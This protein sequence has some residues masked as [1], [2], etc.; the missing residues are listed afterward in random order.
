MIL[1]LIAVASAARS[2]AVSSGHR[3]QVIL[4]LLTPALLGLGI[5]R[6]ESTG[7]ATN[8]IAYA[9][10]AGQSV[11]VTGIVADD[12]R[13]RGS[14]LRIL[15][16][17][18][19]I[20]VG[21][22]QQTV[23][24]R[25]QVHIP[26][27]IEMSYGDRIAVHAV[28]TPTA[29]AESQYL[30]WLADRRV[31][32][33]ALA[34]SGSVELLG[35]ADIG[36]RQ[37]LAVETRRAL[38]GSLR[39]TLPAPLSGIAQGMITGRQDAIDPELRAK[40][41]DT[42]LSH[43]IV[44]S[45]SNLTL[46]TAIVMAA[47]AWLIG[48]RP[49][50]L[51]A[52]LAALAYGT[53]I[54]PD[55]PV[56]RAMWMAVVFAAAHMLGRG[57]SALYAVSAT[58]ALMVA[59]EPHVLL[60]LSFQLTLAGTLG[61]IVL[62]PSLAQDFLAGQRGLTGAVRDAAL[63]TL[64]ATLATMPLIV[65]HFERAALIGLLTN[66]V[67]TPLFSWMLLG[68]AATA[69]LGTVSESAASMLAWPLSWLPLRWL[70]LVAEQGS[71]IPGAGTAIQGFGHAHLVLVYAAML[72]AS[73]RPHHER[74]AR[75]SR[76]SYRT[77]TRAQ[78]QR[79][80]NP[81]AR[82]GL[83]F[84]P[85]L[86]SMVRPA[87]I[88][89]VAAALAA[90]LWLAASSPPQTRLMIHYFD[91]GQ[92]DSALL[93]APEGHTIL[94]DTGERSLD[95]LGAL[96][97]HLPSDTQRIDFVVITHPQ[98][99]HGEALWAVLDHYDLGQVLLSAQADRTSFGRRLIELLDQRRVTRVEARPGQQIEFG[100]KTDLILDILWPPSDGLTEQ[101]LSD[102]NSSSIVIRARF[103]DAAFLFTG[104]IN[105]EQ[106]LDL[107]RNPCPFSSHPCELRADVLKV[108]HQGS[109]NSSSTLFLD[110]VRP[111]L[112]ILSAGADNPYGH[113]HDEV[114]ASLRRIGA[115]PL[116]TAERGDISVA[117]DGHS[118]SLTTQR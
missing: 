109:R 63:V 47:S 12:P 23:D 73:A 22:E 107:A 85:N 20:E 112:A 74:V 53:L 39:A 86:G 19:R 57:A 18:E 115:T 102:P 96:R 72:I 28:L 100:G 24:D 114:I 91:V 61:I 82:V 46:L 45:G 32:A 79:T 118:I 92:G 16:D 31:A 9:E 64:V 81:I 40:L 21:S 48:R 77:Q 94:I 8:G 98:S 93:V 62:M 54:G 65:L 34:R 4:L 84:I 89:G 38:N 80:S 36:W 13:L 5:W 68:T 97:D 3:I 1:T 41:N 105:V 29:G 99:D 7:L 2:D 95:L 50:A 49:A 67:V 42:S 30:Q 76:P 71:Q 103:G 101:A 56:Q 17:A 35:R 6:A 110:A 70:V 117:T 104:D 111:T 69:V 33:S 25:I 10:L 26:D 51:L 87:L 75:W 58:A 116:I 90:T 60:D 52:I 59:L 14:G 27:A 43:L 88:T 37:S 11:R 108:A 55:P 78:T 15:L 113:P 66:L 83:E 106:E 44:I